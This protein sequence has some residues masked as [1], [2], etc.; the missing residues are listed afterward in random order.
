MLG[1]VAVCGG[2]GRR[3]PFLFMACFGGFNALCCCSGGVVLGC[4][5]FVALNGVLACSRGGC[6]V[7]VLLMFDLLCF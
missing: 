4:G 7:F 1:F 5:L 3:P 6:V 2:A